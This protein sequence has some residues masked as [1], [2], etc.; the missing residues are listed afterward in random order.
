M[1]HVSSPVALGLGNQGKLARCMWKYG[2]VSQAEYQVG[3]G[4]LGSRQNNQLWAQSWGCPEAMGHA[5]SQH[6]LLCFRITSGI[7]K[8][9]CFI[10]VKL[11]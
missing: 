10:N 7:G 3:Q 8:S 2:L 11:Y 9:F 6:S 1:L 4:T 5:C